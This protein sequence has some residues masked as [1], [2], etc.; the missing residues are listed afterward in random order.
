MF[1]NKS[2]ASCATPSRKALRRGVSPHAGRRPKAEGRA[3]HFRGDRVRVSHRLPVEGL[4]EG[5]VRSIGPDPP[6]LSTIAESRLLPSSMAGGI[7]RVRRNGGDCLDVAKHRWAHGQGPAGTGCRVAQPDGPGK[8][9]AS[10]TCWSTGVMSRSP[11]SSP[12]STDMMFRSLKQCSTVL[13]FRLRSMGARSFKPTKGMTGNSPTERFTKGAT[14][15][16]SAA[17]SVAAAALRKIGD[18]LSKRPTRG[19]IASASWLSAVRR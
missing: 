3:G 4:T 14:V 6:I 18:G 2:G 10:V 13:S 16:G 1:W 9:T 15:Q 7:G 8:K 11:S 19:T 5:P 12:E 17:R